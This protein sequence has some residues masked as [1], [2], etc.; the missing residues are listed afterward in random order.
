MPFRRRQGQRR[1]PP[2]PQRARTRY[3][4]RPG[5]PHLTTSGPEN[6]GR[7]LTI[8]VPTPKGGEAALHSRCGADTERGGDAR[9]SSGNHGVAYHKD[10]SAPGAITN[11]LTTTRYES[12]TMPFPG[13]N[14]G[15]SPAGA[16]DVY[17]QNAS[18]SACG[19]R[20][21]AGRHVPDAQVVVR[22]YGDG[23]SA[24][25][26]RQKWRLGVV[27]SPPKRLALDR[28]PVARLPS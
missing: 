3:R 26:P 19:R 2:A 20:R 17:T 10:G 11:R 27:P 21:R 23:S 25:A 8:K 28:E 22:A 18:R 4:A 12:F 16:T 7:E 13:R 1:T 15:W 24:G 5:R 6:H 9:S 14:R